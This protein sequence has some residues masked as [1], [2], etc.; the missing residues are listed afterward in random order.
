[1]TETRDDETRGRVGFLGPALLPT[2]R[3]ALL[4]VA[5]AAGFVTLGLKQALAD[6]RVTGKPLFGGDCGALN[7]LVPNE[8]G[9]EY[10][11][12]LD[13]GIADPRGFLTKRFSFTKNQQA[14]LAAASPAD[15]SGVQ[16]ALRAAKQDKLRLH[17]DCDAPAKGQV[18]HTSQRITISS[19][20]DPHEARA[21][22]AAQKVA[23]VV[24][25]NAF[26]GTINFSSPAVN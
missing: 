20:G 4:G 7:K 22:V 19:W 1:V 6:S 23:P 21:G 16:A 17:F 25:R 5:A 9:P 26:Q 3:E 11:R 14:A 18:M 13:E 2:R 15:I 10:I 12:L 8:Y 24:S